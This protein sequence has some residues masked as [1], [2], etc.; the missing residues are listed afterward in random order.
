MMM[1]I[2]DT[3]GFSCDWQRVWEVDSPH[4]GFVQINPSAINPTSGLM[5]RLSTSLGE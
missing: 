4:G 2:L 5:A 1:A 3:A